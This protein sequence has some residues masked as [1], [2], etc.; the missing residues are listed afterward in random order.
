MTMRLLQKKGSGWLSYLI[1]K[2]RLV[3]Q[4]NT[5]SFPI[6][7]TTW[8]YVVRAYV[9]SNTTL[10]KG[11]VPHKILSPQEWSCS[12]SEN[13]K[14]CSFNIHLAEVQAATNTSLRLRKGNNAKREWMH[15]SIN[16][17][18]KRHFRFLISFENLSEIPGHISQDRLIRTW[19]TTHPVWTKKWHFP[20]RYHSGQ[21]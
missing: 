14:P 11:L 4:E 9:L 10:T 8:E 2:T 18:V 16:P 19:N 13:L 6:L 1:P 5:Q 7:H 3:L 15:R 17:V 20:V 21:N 12:P